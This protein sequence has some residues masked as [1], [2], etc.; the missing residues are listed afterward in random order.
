MSIIHELPWMTIAGCVPKGRDFDNPRRQPGGAATHQTHRPNGALSTAASWEKTF[1]DP[2]ALFFQQ[3][4]VFGDE[5]GLFVLFPLIFD[6]VGD[7]LFVARHWS[8][9]LCASFPCAK[10]DVIEDLSETT[11]VPMQHDVTP[12]W[13]YMILASCVPPG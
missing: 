2:Y 9:P 4:P 6:V 7:H 5:I 8:R 3:T 10:D 11:H 1:V 12:R 13:G